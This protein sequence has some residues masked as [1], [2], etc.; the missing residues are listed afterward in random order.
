MREIELKEQIRESA[1]K[2]ASLSFKDALSFA[3]NCEK[4]ATK[5]YMYLYKNLE[6]DYQKE[7]F[8][9]FVETERFHDKKV[10]EIFKTLFPNE[11]PKPVDLKA[12]EE[13]FKKKLK[14]VKDYLDILEIAMEIEKLA[15]EVYLT[16][17]EH[18]ENLEYKKIFMEF[19]NDEKEHYMF[20]VEEYEFYRRFKAE[21]AL[22]ELI[23]DLYKEKNKET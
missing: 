21:E 6:R 20:V 14:T 12:W 22:K 18:S 5:L 16:L 11:R 8:K 15:E 13:L 4:E 2:L 9:K 1:K 7:N 17:K 23:K 3:I 19:A 10:E